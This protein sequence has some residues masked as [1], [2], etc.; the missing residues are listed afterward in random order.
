MMS[1]YWL[2]TVPAKI[3]VDSVGLVLMM[4][5][6]GNIKAWNEST[7]HTIRDDL[8]VL[9]RN[10]WAYVIRML[11]CADDPMRRRVD[12]MLPDARWTDEAIV[13]EPMPPLDRC[14][15][16]NDKETTENQ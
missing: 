4:L 16:K 10:G 11:G 9:N 6:E 8:V 15:I 12:K 1:N 2:D 5:H 3:W 13:G 14:L 7:F